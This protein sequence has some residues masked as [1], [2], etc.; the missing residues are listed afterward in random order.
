MSWIS[1]I[2][3]LA[4]AICNSKHPMENPSPQH[5]IKYWI[6]ATRAGKGNIQGIRWEWDPDANKAQTSFFI[7]FILCNQG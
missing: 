2:L 3:R 6:L 5:H 7:K 4:I 1:I